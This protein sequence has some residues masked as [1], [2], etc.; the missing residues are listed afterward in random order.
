[1]PDGIR[2]AQAAASQTCDPGPLASLTSSMGFLVGE[3]VALE[4]MQ[5]GMLQLNV[6]RSSEV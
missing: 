2:A 4:L 6:L 3:R 1:M 5:H